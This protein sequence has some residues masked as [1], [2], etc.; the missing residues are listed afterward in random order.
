MQASI[1]KLKS[2]HIKLLI[3]SADLK[4]RYVANQIIVQALASNPY[5]HILC[6][7]NMAIFTQTLLNFSCYAFVVGHEHWPEMP[8]LNLWTVKIV[9]ENFPLPQ[10]IK[11][12]YAKRP[13]SN[14]SIPMEVDEQCRIKKQK[15]TID[16]KSI[17]GVD[18]VKRLHLTRDTN[19]RAFIPKNGINLKRIALEIESLNKI[20]SDFI[21]LQTYSNSSD[22]PTSS[23]SFDFKSFKGYEKNAKKN[24]KRPL[25]LY[26]ELTIHKIQNNP[27]KIKKIKDKKN[28][29]KKMQK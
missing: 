27:N 17:V 1:R 10:T 9:A 11:E 2:G 25:T 22:E 5:I 8:E 21:S 12:H 26:R 3:L 13:D 6:V 15:E 4:P 24:G 20:K 28:K 18:D 23:S 16:T 14:T 19:Q 29:K 7:A